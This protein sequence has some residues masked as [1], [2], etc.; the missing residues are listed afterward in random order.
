MKDCKHASFTDWG[1]Y[2][3]TLYN[4]SDNNCIVQYGTCA[5]NKYCPHKKALSIEQENQRLREVIKDIKFEAEFNGNDESVQ[6]MFM[7]AQQVLGE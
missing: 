7:I 6:K 1:I 5:A 4:P 2:A 3:C